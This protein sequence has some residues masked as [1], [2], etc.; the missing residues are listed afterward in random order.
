MKNEPR[1]VE[2]EPGRWVADKSGPSELL[3]E[4]Y[5]EGRQGY[6]LMP[7]THNLGEFALCETCWVDFGGPEE[8]KEEL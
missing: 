5:D 1:V 8:C 3:C 7:A 6:C 2:A 4:G